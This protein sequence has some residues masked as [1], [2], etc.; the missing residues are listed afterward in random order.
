MIM[1]YDL[2]AFLGLAPSILN[3]TRRSSLR[4]FNICIFLSNLLQPKLGKKCASKG[5]L[6][7]LQV[8]LRVLYQRIKRS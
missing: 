2:R 1:S 4:I 3:R 5:Y 7:S 8:N 6:L